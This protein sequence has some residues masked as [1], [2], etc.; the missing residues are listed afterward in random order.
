MYD[1]SMDVVHNHVGY[2]KNINIINTYDVVQKVH[3]SGV[4]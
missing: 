3:D 4:V 2:D 1:A